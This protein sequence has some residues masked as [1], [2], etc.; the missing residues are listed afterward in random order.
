MISGD[1]EALRTFE[2]FESKFGESAYG[3]YAS[4][5]LGKFYF[6]QDEFTKAKEKLEKVARK[7]KFVFADAA[8][9]YLAKLKSK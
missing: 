5:Q 1:A 3:E 4:F 8:A 2:N 9:D 6:F 7:E